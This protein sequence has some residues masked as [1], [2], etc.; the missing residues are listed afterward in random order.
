MSASETG[1]TFI[2]FSASAESADDTGRGSAQP[3]VVGIPHA[4]RLLAE[5]GLTRPLTLFV[6]EQDRVARGS[7][8]GTVVRS[9]GTLFRLPTR[10]LSSVRR[11]V[12]ANSS[13][14][15]M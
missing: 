5:S 7:P 6:A 13:G 2:A 12:G 14:C 11:N 8:I 9:S 4:G 10:A 3:A 15:G 1:K